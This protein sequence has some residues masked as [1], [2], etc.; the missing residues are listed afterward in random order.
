MSRARDL[1][2]GAQ[3]IDCF[4]KVCIIGAFGRSHDGCGFRTRRF[5]RG[6]IEMAGDRAIAA[7]P[8]RSRMAGGFTHKEL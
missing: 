7:L 3:T 5:P 4:E 2:G 8:H 1:S 6:A